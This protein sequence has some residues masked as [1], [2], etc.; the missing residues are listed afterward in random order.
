MSHIVDDYGQNY[1]GGYATSS[2]DPDDL[3]VQ[4]STFQ[5]YV[6]GTVLL[7]FLIFFVFLF[8]SGMTFMLMCY[9][10]YESFIEMSC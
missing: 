2:F 9:A 4:T 8:L 1:R 10:R 7:V 6:S 3:R 5:N